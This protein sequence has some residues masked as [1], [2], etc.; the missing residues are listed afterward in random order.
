M[1][2]VRDADTYFIASSVPPSRLERSAA[3]GVDVSHRG[4]KP[5]FVRVDRDADGVDT[6]TVP[7]F[8]GNNMFNTLGNLSVYPRAGLLFVDFAGAEPDATVGGHRDRVG[9]A[10]TW[11]RS[12]ARSVCCAIGCATMLRIEGAT[13][14]ALGSGAALAVPAGHRQLGGGR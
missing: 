11:R 7:D 13:G 9:R 12:P 4:G 10:R 1:A 14:V 8:S 5:G 6:L 3:H 2:L